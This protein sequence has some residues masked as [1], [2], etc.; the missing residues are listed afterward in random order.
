[1]ERAESRPPLRGVLRKFYVNTPKE[2]TLSANVIM[3]EPTRDG[4]ISAIRNFV[5][6]GA[7]HAFPLLGPANYLVVKEPGGRRS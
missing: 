7:R 4:W 2:K 6:S 5:L 3:G 1:V